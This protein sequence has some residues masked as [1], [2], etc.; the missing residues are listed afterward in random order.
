[1]SQGEGVRPPG[2]GS[3]SP[4]VGSRSEEGPPTGGSR[5][6]GL[7]P[8]GRRGSAHRSEPGRGGSA[9]R[10][11]ESPPTGGEPGRGGSAHR[12]EESPPTGGEPGRGGSAHRG[13]GSA[14]RGVGVCPPGQRTRTEENFLGAWIAQS[15]QKKPD[16]CTQ[17]LQTSVLGSGSRICDEK[18]TA[19]S[20]PMSHRREAGV[21]SPCRLGRNLFWL[22]RHVERKSLWSKRSMGKLHKLPMCQLENN[23]G[24]SEQLGALFAEQTQN[25]GGGGN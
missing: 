19:P 14:H 1:M 18:L 10:R 17:S 5:G 2:V 13:E 16:L 23:S 9:H 15:A 22:K 3:R 11:E 21:L 8:L 20:L 12:R 4:G 7:R 6:E 25:L 24:S